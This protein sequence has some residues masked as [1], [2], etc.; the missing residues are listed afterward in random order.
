ML[1]SLFIIS[2]WKNPATKSSRYFCNLS[3]SL[4]IIVLLLSIFFIFF[5]YL[6]FFFLFFIFNIFFSDLKK[7]YKLMNKL[8]FIFKFFFTDCRIILNFIISCYNRTIIWFFSN[9]LALHS[10]IRKWIVFKNWLFISLYWLARE[11]WV[12]WPNQTS[13]I[14]LILF[15]AKIA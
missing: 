15:L 9:S 5:C 7:F 3:F 8:Q 12:C 11:S 1:Y 14:A 6:L 13:S 2:S 10:V 4:S